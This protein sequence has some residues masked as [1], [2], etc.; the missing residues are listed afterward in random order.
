MRKQVLFVLMAML[1][2]LLF[3]SAAQLFADA[4][5]STGR[6]GDRD[7]CFRR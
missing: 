6:H 3:C 1:F 2:G 5:D 7:L 4:G